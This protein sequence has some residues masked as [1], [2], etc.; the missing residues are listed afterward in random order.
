MQVHVYTRLATGEVI[1]HHGVL[2]K[3]NGRAFFRN[4]HTR[5]HW[6]TSLSN[7]EGEVRGHS[8]WFEEPNRKKAINALDKKDKERVEALL[9]KTERTV[10]RLGL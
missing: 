10:G 2:T 3:G 4:S 1:E 8:V 6:M 9:A 5:H 7:N